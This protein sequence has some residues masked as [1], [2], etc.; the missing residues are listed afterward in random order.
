MKKNWSKEEI[1]ILRDNYNKVSN[2]KLLKLLPG[3]DYKGIYKK[4]YKLGIR[5]DKTIEKLN[6][7]ESAKRGEKSSSWKGGTRRTKKG[8]IQIKAPGHPR[9]DFDGYVME[10]I[11]VFENATGIRV[12][13]ELV[14]HHLDGN[15]E[16]N[17]ISNLC[18][19][20]FGGHSA[21][22]NRMRS[23]ERKNR[24]EQSNFDGKINN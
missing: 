9:A 13:P 5:K 10:H 20:T 22:H 12:T 23:K 8:Y 18:L 6:R 24:N 11:A 4:A 15:K 16:N 2:S 1:E 3:R 21:Y 17:D 14:V 7:I 19:M